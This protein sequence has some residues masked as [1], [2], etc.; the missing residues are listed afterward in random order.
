MPRRPRPLN[1]LL[2]IVKGVVMDDRTR[3][4]F[5]TDRYLMNELLAVKKKESLCLFTHLL[6]IAFDTR[7]YLVCV[8]L[9]L[10][11]NDSA[12]DIVDELIDDSFPK[13]RIELKLS[14]LGL[15]SANVNS[16][17]VNRVI[18]STL[19]ISLNHLRELAV[20]DKSLLAVP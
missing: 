16:G 18:K 12:I 10:K 17:E 8:V 5:G 6:T 3:S 1:H 13:L 15:V 19:E 20:D 7:S 9:R 2:Q 14:D 11:G 4:T